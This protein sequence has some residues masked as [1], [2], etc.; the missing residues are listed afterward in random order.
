MVKTVQALFN[1]PHYIEVLDGQ[2][3]PKQYSP[4][5]FVAYLFLNSPLEILGEGG[6]EKAIGVSLTKLKTEA[7]EKVIMAS[8]VPSET[9]YFKE[10]FA[11]FLTNHTKKMTPE[12]FVEFL[13]DQLTQHQTVSV[14]KLSEFM[15]R[16]PQS[17]SH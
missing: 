1:L 4:L 5:Q 12:A 14:D 7:P 8:E 2:S 13:Q 9:L 11:D 6:L 17:I 15:L 10:E 16:S 3:E